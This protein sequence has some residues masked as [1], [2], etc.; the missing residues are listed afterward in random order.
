MFPWLHTT[1]TFLV[2]H[3]QVNPLRQY[4]A[5]ITTT[6]PS[7]SLSETM[8]SAIA[9]HKQLLTGWELKKSL[10]NTGSQIIYLD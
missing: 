9:L 8:M 3:S 1:F 4:H 5:I 7:G 10:A 2:H 6:T